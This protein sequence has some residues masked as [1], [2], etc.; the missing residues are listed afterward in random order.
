MI[1][2]T[3]QDLAEDRWSGGSILLDRVIGGVMT[4]QAIMYVHTMAKIKN[5]ERLTADFNCT[6]T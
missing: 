2:S 1:S 6:P 4:T 5:W 3:D